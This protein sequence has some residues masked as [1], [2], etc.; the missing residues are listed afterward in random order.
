MLAS[1]LVFKVNAMADVLNDDSLR[2]DPISFDLDEADPED[3]DIDDILQ[4]LK[5]GLF[6][7]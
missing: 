5:A 2:V 6:A 4:H 7:T 3:D 1:R